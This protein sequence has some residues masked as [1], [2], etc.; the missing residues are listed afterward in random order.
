[1][2]NGRKYRVSEMISVD[3]FKQYE[4]LEPKLTY[5]VT[6]E[7]MFKNIKKAYQA[8]N[9]QRFADSAVILHNIMAG[10]QDVENEQRVHPALIMCAL[11]INFEGEDSTIYDEAVILGKIDDW[12]KEGLNMLD[13]F[14][15]A[16]SSIKGFRET[17]LQYIQSQAKN[18]AKELEKEEKRENEN[19]Q[20]GT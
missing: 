2:A 4:K 8:V 5:G 19:L 3:R 1:M 15:L 7:E 14:M 18:L 12:Q 6:F 13:F 11:V 20:K 16:L 9:E 10:I 17:Y